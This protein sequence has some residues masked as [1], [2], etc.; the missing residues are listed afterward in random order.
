M[1]RGGCGA[2]DCED[3]EDGPDV[4]NYVISFGDRARVGWLRL[5]CTGLLWINMFQF[6]IDILFIIH[7]LVLASHIFPRHHLKDFICCCCFNIGRLVF[8][9]VYFIVSFLSFRV[10]NYFSF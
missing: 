7:F 5:A 4:S 1:R 3:D 9:D 6:F 10:I 8:V 2:G